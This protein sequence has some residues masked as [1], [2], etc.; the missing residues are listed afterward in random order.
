MIA[1]KNAVTFTQAVCSPKPTWLIQQEWYDV[2]KPQTFKLG[3]HDK[4]HPPS[5]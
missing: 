5:F 2:N 3:Q 4:G 1:E